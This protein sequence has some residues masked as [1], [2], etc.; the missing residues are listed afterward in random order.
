[1]GRWTGFTSVEGKSS[2]LYFYLWVIKT[3]VNFKLFDLHHVNPT[4]TLGY[5]IR[6]FSVNAE[7]LTET[8][9]SSTKG[10]SMWCLMVDIMSLKSRAEMTPFFPLSFWANAWR[11]CSNCSSWKRHCKAVCKSKYS[12][13]HTVRSKKETETRWRESIKRQ[14]TYL[15]E[16]GE[17]DVAEAFLAVVPK[18][19]TDELAVPVERNMVVHCGLAEDVPHI[20][21]ST[22][23]IVYVS[24]SQK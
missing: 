11:A 15:Q 17:L 23:K 7:T 13:S 5:T 22:N 21:C 19:Q 1:M 24:V 12:Q 18:V 3:S 10:V 2:G 9:F 6:R 16:L 14:S 4:S 20:L 8:R